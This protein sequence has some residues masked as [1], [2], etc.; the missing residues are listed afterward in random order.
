MGSA[1]TS[2]AVQLRGCQQAP[3]APRV[4]PS[5]VLHLAI[6]GGA[7]PTPYKAQSVPPEAKTLCR[8]NGDIYLFV[9][10]FFVVIHYRMP[11]KTQ[12]M[13]VEDVRDF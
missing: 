11:S 4:T 12:F 13:L 9:G 5:C 2:G 8:A 3:R 6:Q 7:C 10:W 1:P